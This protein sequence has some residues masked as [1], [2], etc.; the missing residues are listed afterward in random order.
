MLRSPV[1]PTR[2]GTALLFVL[3]AGLPALAA[4]Q[5]DAMQGG[6]DP[7]AEARSALQEAI[8]SGQDPYPDR[9][10]WRNA[11]DEA[12][13]A[14]EAA[15]DDPEA[16]TVLAE[17]LSRS[18]WLGPAWDAWTDLFEAGYDV[19]ANLTS[20]F[21]DTGVE[22][23]YTAYERGDLQRA[24]D[25][26]RGVLDQ[27]PFSKEAN[28]WMGR[29]RLEQQRPSDAVDY[30]R[31]VVEQDPDDARAEYFLELA[32]EQA[33]W[34]PQAVTTFREGVQHY[35]DGDLD[36]AA[37]ALERATEANEDYA[38]AWA[39]R[40]RV[41][42]DREAY[43]TAGNFYERAVELEPDNE[44]YAFFAEESAR[45]AAGGSPSDGDEDVQAEFE[46]ELDVE[47]EE[48]APDAED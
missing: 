23:A 7:V 15:P 3:V 16:L 12:E 10:A 36:R 32:R 38:Q 17:A 11:I 22:L 30:W 48:P 44:T 29:I 14:V 2:L 13:E 21:V 5:D 24:A 35:E 40:G 31:R 46:Q 27:V 25:I 9:P 19:P 43:V 1:V 20:L 6:P 18:Q 42:F 34:G 33:E 28:V 47:V 41:A 39:W 4:A 45:R 26:Y 37:I 8:D